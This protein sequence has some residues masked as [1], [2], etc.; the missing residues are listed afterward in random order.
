MK[1]VKNV[2]NVKEGGVNRRE[3]LKGGS[4]A[5]AAACVPF[6]IEILNAGEAVAMPSPKDLEGETTVHWNS[7]NV[8][9]GSR[10]A[11]RLHVQDGVI[12]KV[13]TD[14][15]GD[16]SY[17]QQQLRACPRGRSMRQRVYAEERVP[18]PLKRVGT[19][20]EGKFERISWDQVYKEI[21]TRLQ[22]TIKDHT[23]E[24][25]YLSYGTGAL[26]S[27]MGKS[28]PPGQTPVARL[29]NTVGGYLNHYSDYSTCQIT[30]GMPYLLGGTWTDANVLSDMENSE[31]AVFF[32]NNPSE[33][34]MSGTKCKTLQ[35]ARFEKN[36][37][38]IIIDP[39]YTDTMVSS[40]D[41][42][43]P[44]RPGTDMALCCALAH[45]MITE[46]LVD[47]AFVNK[48]SMGYDEDTLPS[49]APANSSYKS[50]ILGKGADQTPKTPKWAEKITG[51]PVARI[52]KLAREMASAKPC[53]IC[54]GWGPQRTTN[55]ENQSRAIG[56]LAVLT[57][58][59]G[60]AGGNTG[61]RENAGVALPMVSFPV[62]TNPV[63][64]TVSCFNWYEAID[65]YSNMTALT[66]GVRG[67]E[68]LIAP[69]KFMWSY[70][71]NAITN[72]HG[73][74]NQ[75]HDI[76]VD[77]TKCE[78]IV[79]IDTTLSVSARYADYVLPSCSNIE[80]YD[81]T[82]DGD[83]NMGYV[84]FDDKCIEPYGESRSI[85]DICAGIAK[86]IGQ[87]EK[88][89]EGRTQYEWLEYL[90]AE[91]RKNVPN[92][93]A[94]LKE[95]FAAGVYKQYVPTNH[96]AYKAF[97]DNPARNPLD[98]PSGLIEIYSPRL[99][100][101]SNTWELEKG[102]RITAVAE[103]IEDT[104]GHLSP[105]VATFPLQLIGHHYKQR[106]H[107]T[108]ANCWWLQEVAPSEIWIN[109]IDA[110]ARKIKHWDKV[111]VYND[112]GVTFVSAKVTPRI[113]PGVVSLPEGA[114]HTPAA[115]GDD[116]NGCVNVLTRL[117]PTALSKGNPHHS[118]LVQIQLA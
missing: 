51:I 113:M 108:Y 55:G 19:R 115:N 95:A 48:Y 60:I 32:G 17:G 67:R 107:S 58:N 44:I 77:D 81:W 85:Y 62:L 40:G 39:R 4:L 101:M 18:Y 46:N 41:E 94:T 100:E 21:G 86:E 37:K 109:P 103:Y 7:C 53:F 102:Q 13:E 50:Y 98:T 79:V 74:I 29:M 14:N 97:R 1:N 26:G 47:L 99:A 15:T 56:M 76:L 36:T 68:K 25:V 92:L 45:V 75:M 16:D 30:V 96:I 65:D 10:C 2:K 64:T 83:A 23:N 22:N 12:T 111:K 87:E 57:G 52:E 49:D 9:C 116:M 3:V 61:A 112:R 73:G 59:I 71:G 11:L 84:I 33:T 31:L 5:L 35:H 69:I 20:G 104:E 89:T 80:E 28:W 91:S 90:Y 88:F 118:N 106:T 117:Q 38:V 93:P 6:S 43:V 105:E 114:W 63:A 66:A 42:W 27:T 72:Q 70:A 24:S 110:K 34:R 78:T 8:N 82:V 54:Q